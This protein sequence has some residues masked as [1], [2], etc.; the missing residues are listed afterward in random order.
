MKFPNLLP[1]LNSHF[2]R[3]FFDGDGC[4]GKYKNG[5]YYML[6][7]EISCCS[8]D[9]METMACILAS[10]GINMQTTVKNKQPN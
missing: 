5:K 1:N 9:F 7:W 6:Q 3:G 8:K 10:Y 2:I 4:I